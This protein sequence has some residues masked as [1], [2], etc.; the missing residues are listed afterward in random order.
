M[1]D[2]DSALEVL[3]DNDLGDPES[4]CLHLTAGEYMLSY[5]EKIMRSN[6]ILTGLSSQET[7]VTCVNGDTLSQDNYTSFPL[8][9]GNQST[10]EISGLSFKECAR[11][12]LFNGSSRVTLEDCSFRY[13]EH[14]AETFLLLKIELVLSMVLWQKVHGI[15]AS[16]SKRHLT[17]P[18]RSILLGML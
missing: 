4:I 7:M 13:I 2:M 11:P 3:T 6:F 8:H 12:L 17:L 18:V 15:T 16:I 1:T 5:S 9:F 10:I 14:V